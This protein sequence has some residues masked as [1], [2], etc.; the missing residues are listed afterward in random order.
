MIAVTQQAEFISV[1][2]RWAILISITL[3]TMQYAM[4]ILVVS[5]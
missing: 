1:L 5:V 3:A 2:R 4:A